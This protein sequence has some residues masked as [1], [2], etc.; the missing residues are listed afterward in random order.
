M[1]LQ[2]TGKGQLR[3][4][5]ELQLAIGPLGRDA[6]GSVGGGDKGFSV[7][8]SYSHAAVMCYV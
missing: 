4:G 7:I 5:G 1:L 3:L 2:F 8:Y 6:S